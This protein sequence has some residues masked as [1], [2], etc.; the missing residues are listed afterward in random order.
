MH[1]RKFTRAFSSLIQFE[2]GYSN[3]TFDRGGETKFG[4]CKKQYPT[5]DIK[6]LTLDQAKKIYCQDYWLPYN[7]DRIKSVK[8][9]EKVFQATV[10]TGAKQSHLILQR[11]LKAVGHK[12]LIEDGIL[13]IQTLKAVNEARQECLLPALRSE[14]A[15]VYR[16]LA[17]VKPEQNKFKVG[18]LRRAYH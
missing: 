3:D 4:L 16:L 10:H 12:G 6:S 15:G 18:W 17:A 2:G 7:Y 1:S 11:A 13:G 5:L 14:Q 9:A 8:V